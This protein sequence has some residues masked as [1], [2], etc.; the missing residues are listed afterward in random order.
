MHCFLVSAFDRRSDNNKD[1]ISDRKT[2]QEFPNES[3]LALHKDQG[4]FS[5]DDNQT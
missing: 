2:W 3:T 1:I 5:G 4:S